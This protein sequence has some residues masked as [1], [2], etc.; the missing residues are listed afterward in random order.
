MRCVRADSFDQHRYHLRMTNLEPF[1]SPVDRARFIERYDAVMKLWPVSYTDEVVVTSFG[2]T[3]VVIS[4]AEDAPPLVLLHGAATTAAAWIPAIAALSSSY[5]C[6]CIDTITDG[7]KSVATRRVNG[8]QDFVAWLREVFSALGIGDARV[9]GLSYGGWLAAL[10][11]IHAPDLVN[12]LVLVC[13]A[14]TFTPLTAGFMVRVLI[15]SLLRSKILVDRAIQWMSSTP[16]APSDPVLTLVSANL[17]TCRTLRPEL[18]QPVRLTDVDLRRIAVPTTVVI[19]DQEILYRGGPR[20]ALAR[21]ETLIPDV[22]TELVPHAGHVLTLDA[23]EVV[24]KA[25]LAR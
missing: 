24:V 5:R 17:L 22:R 15:A 13:P 2:A 18:P 16:E 1:R 19:G 21:A 10:L 25:M 11:A 8:A 3:H 12:R 23:P 6:Y 7:N 14:G 20:A 9:G 4:G